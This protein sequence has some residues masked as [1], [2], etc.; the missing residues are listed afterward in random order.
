M[1]PPVKLHGSNS[2]RS[3]ARPMLASPLL[4]LLALLLAAC[5]K[6]ATE[7]KP[8]NNVGA[9]SA[10][11]TASAPSSAPS[12]ATS[13]PPGAPLATLGA[14]RRA[15][16]AYGKA[17]DV[18]V[19]AGAA[20]F[21]FSTSADKAGHRPLRGALLDATL[22][23]ADVPDPLLYFR[24]AWED[25][26]HKAHVL[27]ASAVTTI[28]CDEFAG[29]PGAGTSGV[30][31][32]GDVEGVTLTTTY[33]PT[34]E[35]ALTVHTT[36]QNLPE[37]ASIADE[38]NPGTAEPTFP[39]V[40]VGW[41]GTYETPRVTIAEVGLSISI[42]GKTM[43]AERHLVH[44][45]NES[46]PA[47][48]FLRHQGADVSRTLTLTAEVPITPDAELTAELSLSY[49]EG[50]TP[51]PVQVLLRRTDGG[52]EPAP[53][54][55]STTEHPTFAEGRVIYLPKGRGSVKVAPGAYELVATHGP[56]HT[57]HTAHASLAAGK[58]PS[59]SGTLARVVSPVGWTSADLH[60]HAAPSPDSRVSLDERVAELA[61]MG[62]D[63]AVATDHNRITDYGPALARTT[64]P[65]GL[66]FVPGVEVTTRAL[67]HFNVFPMALP[68]DAA[69]ELAV[70]A[71]WD[72]AAKDVFA[73]S[74]AMGAKVVE[75][76]HARMAPGI[77]YFDLARFDAK[78]GS[79][80][81]AF[82]AEFD[83]LEV[84]NGFWLEHPDRVRE[85][86]ADLVGLA[87]RGK[88]VAAVGNSDSHKL[89]FEEA[90]WPRTWVKTAGDGA[91]ADRVVAG[92]LRAETTISAGPFVDMTVD[93]RPIGATVK[94]TPGKPLR[95]HVRV[96]GP[97]WIPVSRVE[98]HVDD[99][100]AKTITVTGPA[101]DGV[102]FDADVELIVEHDAVLFAWVD[103]DTPLDAVM[104]RK[105]VR[106]IGMTG[107]VWVDADGD[108]AV[109]VGPRID[110]PASP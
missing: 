48:L 27:F 81:P 62:V 34:G 35:G 85:G 87:R 107:L 14:H 105:G 76:N 53:L 72:V 37:G 91:L 110:K 20:R 22:T 94:A 45:A 3:F 109:H 86:A 96:L 1:L 9:A 104:G 90:G 108:G 54:P 55:V 78:D 29:G 42:T 5:P 36:A 83:A 59:V 63:F 43:K 41:E 58:N 6:D 10:V 66:R 33:C 84:H 19:P 2:F 100:V 12:A 30:L 56:M 32:R 51:V 16:H 79:G 21:V 25:K 4:L 71:Y 31:V 61:C 49:A 99:T 24:Q 38:L 67:G 88:H 13:L 46:F 11:Q 40:N 77:G 28:G 68:T 44:V 7:T 93:G 69:P 57:L 101:K 73:G 75:V 70:P 23:D 65:G 26:A 102:R 64:L 60:L 82:S 80:G 18:I 17:G 50:K 98:L 74:R 39:G 52:K 92:L 47:A 89:F 8:P 15:F 106:P 97:A 95:V 103:S